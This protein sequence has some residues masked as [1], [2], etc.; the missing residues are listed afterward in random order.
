MG[1][2]NQ[3]RY[4][5]NHKC[6]VVIHLHNPEMRYKR[7]KGIIGNLGLGG[8]DPRDQSRLSYIGETDQSHI[9]DQFK[10][11][12]KLE[13]FPSL[14][15]FRAAGRLLVDVANLAFPFPPRPP[16]TIRIRSPIWAKS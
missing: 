3:S 4:V 1:S 13:L 2:L 7:C 14:P 12:R 11:Q 15:W 6:A 16:T 10:A 8:A 5:R 9:G